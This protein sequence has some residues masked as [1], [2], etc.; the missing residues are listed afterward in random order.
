[1]SEYPWKKYS[2]SDSYI[3]CDSNY[4]KHTILP[5]NISVLF[6]VSAFIPLLLIFKLYQKNKNNKLKTIF[7]QRVYGFFYAELK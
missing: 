3:E 4:Y 7:N 6:I 2:I 5:I 1:M